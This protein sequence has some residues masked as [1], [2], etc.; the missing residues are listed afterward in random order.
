MSGEKGRGRGN[1]SRPLGRE[2]GGTFISGWEAP[3]GKGNPVR[4]KLL[5]EAAL[6]IPQGPHTTEI[7]IEAPSSPT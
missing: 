1:I 3:E 4:R 5:R 6:S 7:T 2:M